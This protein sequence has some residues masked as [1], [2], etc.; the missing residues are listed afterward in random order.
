MVFGDHDVDVPKEEDRDE[1][2]LATVFA[3]EEKSSSAL[4]K[5]LS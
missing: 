3:V 5:S 4:Q 1:R 2:Q